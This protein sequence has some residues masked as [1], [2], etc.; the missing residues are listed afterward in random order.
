MPLP[1]VYT[2]PNGLVPSRDPHEAYTD[3]VKLAPGTYAQ[4]TALGQYTIGTAAN[5]VQ[6]LTVGGSPTGGTFTL[7][8]NAGLTTPLA[9]NATAAQVQAALEALPD[10][11]AGNVVVTGSPGG[12]WAVT[13]Q[14]DLGNSPQAPLLVAANNL[15]GGTSPAVTVAQTTVGVAAGPYYGAY[16]D[17]ATDGRAVCRAF[18]KYATVVYPNGTHQSA[19]GP[20]AVGPAVAPTAT[21]YF[22]G[23]FYTSKLPGLDANGVAD[24]GRMLVGTTAALTNAA[25]ELRMS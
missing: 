21:A 10:V 4:G 23:T 5:S 12:P 14:A 17:N 20:P 8:F 22:T 24:C 7:S 19:G 25:A 16:D 2:G 15:T 3:A 18:L 11:G 1:T 6:T 13:F 9:Y